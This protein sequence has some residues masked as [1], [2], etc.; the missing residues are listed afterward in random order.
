MATPGVFSAHAEVVPSRPLSASAFPRILRARG[1]SSCLAA[2]LRKA[3]L[4]S[5]RTRR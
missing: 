5:P 4:Y 1:G 2:I 3:W